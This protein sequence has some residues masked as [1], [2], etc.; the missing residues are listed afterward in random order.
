VHQLARCCSPCS[1]SPYTP[2]ACGAQRVLLHEYS[3]STGYDHAWCRHVFYPLCIYLSLSYHCL[4]FLANKRCHKSCSDLNSQ[5]KRP[6][7]L[8]LWPFDSKGQRSR[9][10]K[11][12]SE[13]RVTWANSVPILVFLGLSVHKLR[14]MYATDR[15]QTDRRQR[16][17]SLN[18]PAY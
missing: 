16:K 8:D 11:V 14:P 9:T 12:V 6:G 5:S 18:V 3:W 10:F 17:V 13:S 1:S 7:D 2:Y 15:H 4:Y